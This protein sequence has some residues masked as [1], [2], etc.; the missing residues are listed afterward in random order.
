MAQE[1]LTLPSYLKDTHATQIKA[2]HNT[3][4]LRPQWMTQEEQM[5][6]IVK[7][8]FHF[9]IDMDTWKKVSLLR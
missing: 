7:D 3:K 4:F 6:Q 5:T 9:K 2:N 8:R 1:E